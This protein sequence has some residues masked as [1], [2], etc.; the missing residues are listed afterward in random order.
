MSTSTSLSEEDEKKFQTWFLSALDGGTIADSLKT[1]MGTKSEIQ[2]EQ[3]GLQCGRVT[4]PVLDLDGHIPRSRALR[5]K[6][7]L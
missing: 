2:Y 5:S 7:T 3:D 1:L 6:G 4:R